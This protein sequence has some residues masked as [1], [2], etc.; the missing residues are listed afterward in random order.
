MPKQATFQ[1]TK[2]G[3]SVLGVL[4]VAAVASICFYFHT[5]LGYRIPA[6]L[7]LLV[8]SALAMVFEM[9]PVFLAAGLSALVLNFFFIPPILTFHIENSEDTLLFFMYFFVAMVNATLSIKL[10]DR[11]KKIRGKDEA[12]RRLKLYNS[13]LNSLSHELKTPVATLLGAVETLKDNKDVLDDQQQDALLHQLEHAGLRL[14]REVENLLDMSRL[15]ADMV[16]LHVDWCDVDDLF[17]AVQQKLDPGALPHALHISVQ[18]NMPLIR[19]DERLVAQAV[20]NLL[21]NA[22]MH[23]PEGTPIF[24]EA[25]MESD[26]AII[27]VMDQ[28]PGLSHAEQQHVFELFYRS[29][30]A[31]PG[32]TGL[33]LPIAQGFIQAHGGIIRLTSA[34]GHGTVFRIEL[35]VAVSYLKNLRHE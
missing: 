30:S 7:L 19:V 4:A 6:L 10:R 31:R 24:L 22:L 13:L 3:Q 12:D 23:T 27:Q 35:P 16:H 14:N 1:E 2:L 15:Q 33:G 20:Y 17:H 32:G 29:P 26:R 18:P 11:E 5:I 9:L 8:V 25:F 21:S 28:G 34:L